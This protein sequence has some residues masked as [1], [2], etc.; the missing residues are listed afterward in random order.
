MVSENWVYYIF[1]K[2]TPI[3]CFRGF[4]SNGN[5]THEYYN[6]DIYRNLEDIAKYFKL[7]NFHFIFSLSQ[8]PKSLHKIVLTKLYHF[9]SFE[10]KLHVFL[11]KK[12]WG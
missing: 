8:R 12:K 6:D 5:Q 3:Y 2:L 9:W 11:F 1:Y 7:F 10:I 4:P